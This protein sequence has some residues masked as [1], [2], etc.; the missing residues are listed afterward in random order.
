MIMTN[1]LSPQISGNVSAEL[2]ARL[3]TLFTTPKGTVPLN[4]EY[5]FDFSTVDRPPYQAKA[6]YTAEA[7][8]VIRKFEP[9]VKSAEIQFESAAPGKLRPKVVIK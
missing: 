8:R 4:R 3:T 1:F 5:G 6:M 9:S 2:L 7:V